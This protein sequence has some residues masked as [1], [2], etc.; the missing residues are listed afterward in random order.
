M[1]SYL[2]GV[3][4][5][6]GLAPADVERVSRAFVLR[7]F[8]RGETIFSEGKAADAAYILRSG[9]LKMVKLSPKDDP[10]ILEIVVP[11]HLFGMM[12]ALDHRPYPVDAVCLQDSEA[13]RIRIEDF[14]ELLRR[15]PPFS[16]AVY[17]EVGDHLRHS[18]ALR[19]M[20]KE[21]AERRI[22]YILWLL[23]LTLGPEMRLGREEVAEMAGTTVETAIR[24]LGHL[25]K[26]GLIDARWKRIKV[27]KPESLRDGTA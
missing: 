19:S 24:T 25:R 9:L 11:G 5:L 7:R 20:V 2:A 3:P 6:K 4:F 22:G 21:T 23:S 27:L 10:V 16:Q 12:A 26:A 13:Y 8:S 18:Q 14:S 17:A 15:H 1:D